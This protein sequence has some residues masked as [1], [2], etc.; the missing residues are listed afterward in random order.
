MV[1]SFLSA[2]TIN[3]AKKESSDATEKKTANETATKDLTTKSKEPMKLKI[4]GPSGANKFVKFEE[5]EEYP[6]WHET[7]K[8]FKAANLELE[9]EIVPREQYQ[10]V[11]QTLMASASD[12]PDIANLT[13]LNNTTALN[14]AKQGIIL[15]LNSLIDKYSNGNIKRMYKE[16][17]PFAPK[18]ITAPDGKMYWFSSLHLKT[19]KV[20]E[21]AP[22]NLTM[23]IRKDWLEKLG[24]SVPTT[25]E[26]YFNVLKEMRDRDANGNGK[27]DEILAYNLGLFNYAIPQWFG[28]GTGITAIDFETNKVVSPWYQPGIKEYFKYMRRFVEAGIIDVD[29]ITKGGGDAVAQNRVASIYTYGIIQTLEPLVKQEKAEYLPLMPL[30]AVDGI[31]P[32]TQVEPPNLVWQK[33]AITKACK[34]PQAAIAFF[35]VVYS[36]EYATLCQWG[37]EGVTYKEEN[38]V[39][40]LIGAATKSWEEQANK[41]ETLGKT[42]YGDIVFPR[43]Q[44]DNIERELVNIP[45]YKADY[46][47]EAMKYKPYYSNF[48]DNFLAMPTDEQLEEKTKIIN[49]LTTYS[50]ELATKLILGQASLDNWDK[51]MKELKE[52]GLDKLIQID[53]ELYDRYCSIK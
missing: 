37:I 46:Q 52:L 31:T 23:L 34:N 44:L 13:A 27:A 40:L 49:N 22:V 3:T 15:E 48:N 7:E 30:K 9:F 53:Q 51:Y 29:L 21:P 2:C 43:V 25:A 35:D 42:V 26:E 36:D 1:M 17:F 12:L 24:L 14:L 38:G 11:L 5:R 47:L 16:V 20:T 18:L 50:S 28:L 4:L 6:V 10:V 41:R 32:A 39:K 19:Y 33:Y 8:L 45:K